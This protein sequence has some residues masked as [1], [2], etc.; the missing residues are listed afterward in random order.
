MPQE[1]TQQSNTNIIEVAL[2][3]IERQPHP[4][5]LENKS[6][7]K[8][9]DDKALIFKENEDNTLYFRLT[10]EDFVRGCKT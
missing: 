3:D 1:W 7:Q 5:T 8:R 9:S 10:N 4:Y 2:M 6:R